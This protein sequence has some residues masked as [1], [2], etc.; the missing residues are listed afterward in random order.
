MYLKIKNDLSFGKWPNS[1]D[2][3][4]GHCICKIKTRYR[5]SIIFDCLLTLCED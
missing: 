4:F 1:K 3:I 5:K 2:E